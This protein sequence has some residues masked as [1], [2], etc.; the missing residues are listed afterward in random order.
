MGNSDANPA[1]LDALVEYQDGAIVSRQVMKTPGGSVTAFAFDAGQ[2]LSEHTT[3]H[4]ALVQVIDGA[5]RVDL[6][7]K[8]HELGPGEA[9]RLP[10]GVP[11]SVH[12]GTR[13]KMLLV[14][15][16]SEA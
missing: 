13:F 6:A 5:A 3:P 2:G 4:E 12:A 16:R 9:I 1:A 7:G 8:S 11:H 15:L 10:A 14:M